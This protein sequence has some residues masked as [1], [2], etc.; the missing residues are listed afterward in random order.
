M[1]CNVGLAN[2]AAG[3]MRLAKR[4]SRTPHYRYEWRDYLRAKRWPGYRRESC[5]QGRFIA[6]PFI[7]GLDGDW[8]VLVY[9]DQYYVLKRHVRP[10]DFRASGSGMD[11]RAGLDSGIPDE[12]LSFVEKVYHLLDIP[13]L[14][15]DVAFD[16]KRPYLIEFQAVYFGTATQAEILPG[17]FH[18]PRGYVGT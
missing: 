10:G 1:S 14:S 5:Y 9:G 3:A 6:Q 17:V 7:S 16:G 12:V 8:K 2:S 11:Y 15:A 4:F 13:H 18:S